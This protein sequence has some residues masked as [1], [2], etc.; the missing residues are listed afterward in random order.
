M[1]MKYN[2]KGDT[3]IADREDDSREPCGILSSGDS[4]SRPMP[5]AFDMLPPKAQI[6][7]VC[8]SLDGF[9]QEKNRKYGNSALEPV[10]VFSKL[11]AGEQL[12]IRMDDKVSRIKNSDELRKNDVV[13]LMGYLVLVCVQNGWSNFD[14][15]LD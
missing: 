5:P 4:T 9:L 10:R 6:R 13:D 2:G 3:S 11:S 8:E 1:T 7:G 12:K 14:E 15:L